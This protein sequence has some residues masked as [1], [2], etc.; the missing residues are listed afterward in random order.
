MTCSRGLAA[1][2]IAVNSERAGVAQLHTVVPRAFVS[3][4]SA[5]IGFDSAGGR[6][7]MVRAVD[8]IL[9]AACRVESEPA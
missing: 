9:D 7:E 1:G 3:I 6:H 5:A 8:Q 2:S 4:E